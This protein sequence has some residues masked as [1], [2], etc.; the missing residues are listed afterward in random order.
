MRLADSLV[1]MPELAGEGAASALITDPPYSSGGAFRGDTTKG[2]EKYLKTSQ[3]YE[4]IEG[5]TRDQRSHGLWL[6]LWCARARSFLRQGSTFAL[7]TDWRM[8]GVTIDAVQ[9]GG[10]VFR[11]VAPWCKPTSRPQQGRLAAGA[12]FV[13]WGSDGPLPVERDAPASA[14]YI[15]CLA[16]RDRIHPTEKPLRV[17]SWLVELAE[18]GGLVVDPFTGGGSTG[19]AALRSGRTFSGCE[20]SPHWFEVACDALSAE[21]RGSTAHASRAG[22]GALFDEERKP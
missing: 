21:E 14:G 10:L 8:L 5:D 9:V 1:A 3:A 2:L 15:E 17:L 18:R 6:A 16:P 20:L 4:A 12:E 22:Q 11:G 19:V 7:F 13:V